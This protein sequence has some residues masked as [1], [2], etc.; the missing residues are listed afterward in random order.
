MMSCNGAGSP[1]KGSAIPLI[2]KIYISFSWST[3]KFDDFYNAIFNGCYSG[4]IH[5]VISSYE[6]LDLKKDF[7]EILKKACEI[8]KFNYDEIPKEEL[9]QIKERK[10]REEIMNILFEIDYIKNS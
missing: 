6:N 8:G 10:R 7:K 9:K 1:K 2:E 5:Y 3:S 4:D